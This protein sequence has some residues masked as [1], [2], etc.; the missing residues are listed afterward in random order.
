MARS[1]PFHARSTADQVLAGI[2]LSRRTMLVTGC[3]S[4]IGL[5]T[6]KALRANGARVIGMSGTV[7]EAEAACAAAGRSLTAL[8]CDPAD[9]RSVDDA[10]DTLRA[11]APLDA[12]VVNSVELQGFSGLSAQFGLLNRLAELVRERT[13]R[14]AIGTAESRLIA[15]ELSR[16]LQSRGIAVNAFHTDVAGDRAAREARS[17]ARRL[18]ESVTRPFARTAAQRAATP[19]LLA[20]S[21]L[22]ATTTGEFWADCQVSGNPPT[23]P[24]QDVTGPSGATT[25]AGEP[26]R[27]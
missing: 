10:L 4:P 11:A 1:I 22:I 20:A 23:H 3:H 24:T 2:D 7:G 16:R 12:V 5:E 8:G 14:I 9:A 27:P 21:P 26:Q 13:G 19:A 18:I 6:M 15:K 17:F 25:R